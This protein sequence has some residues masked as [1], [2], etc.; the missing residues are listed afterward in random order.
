[1]PITHTGKRPTWPALCSDG[2]KASSGKKGVRILIQS[3][4]IRASLPNVMASLLDYD[5]PKGGKLSLSITLES[6]KSLVD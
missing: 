5:L 6:V 4:L 1:M 2:I 3:K